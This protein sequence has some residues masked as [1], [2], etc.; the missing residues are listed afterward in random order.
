MAGMI[1]ALPMAAPLA[2]GGVLARMAGHAAL[3]ALVWFALWRL[4]EH[5]GLAVAG[6]VIAVVVLGSLLVGH[7]HRS[8]SAA[9][10]GAS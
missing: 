1:L 10:K 2:M 5:L 7:R 6:V 9:S 4:F 8:R 3:R